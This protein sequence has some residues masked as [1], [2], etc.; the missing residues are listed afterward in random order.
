MTRAF[1]GPPGGGGFV[2]HI[3]VLLVKKCPK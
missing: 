1:L 2:N 3:Q